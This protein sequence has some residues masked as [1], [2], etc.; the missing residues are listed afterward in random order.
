MVVLDDIYTNT[1]PMGDNRDRDAV[2][3][4]KLH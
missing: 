1:L 2:K 4:F 3:T